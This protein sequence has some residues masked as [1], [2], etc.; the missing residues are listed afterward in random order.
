M[1]IPIDAKP[2]L[3]SKNLRFLSYFI[4]LLFR[5]LIFVSLLYLLR[6]KGLF[7]DNLVME[8]YLMS[9][10]IEFL[11]YL[12]SELCFKNSLGKIITGSKLVGYD[13]EKPTEGQ[14][15]KRN[16]CRMFP[17]EMLFFFSHLNGYGWHDRLSKTLII[18][19][20]KLKEQKAIN[21]I[22][23]LGEKL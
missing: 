17:F 20:K 6:G 11:Y 19:N 13:L 7:G 3:Q 10:V 1:L 15:L 8:F 23:Q 2:L 4:D 21:E 16:I 22:D 12:I 18:S 9:V 5:I 14:I